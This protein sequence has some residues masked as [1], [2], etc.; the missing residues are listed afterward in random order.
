M[1]V[2]YDVFHSPNRKSASVGALVA[3]TS[4]RFARYFTTTHFHKDKSELSANLCSQMTGALYSYLELNR[5]LPARIILYRDGVGDGQ[6]NYIYN[7]ELVQIQVK[8]IKWRG[9]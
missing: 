6:L 7:T 2:G 8:I 5:K 9:L 4:P 1:V 3:S